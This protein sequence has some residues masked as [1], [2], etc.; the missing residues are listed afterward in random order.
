MST[1]GAAGGGEAASGERAVRQLAAG[2]FFGTSKVSRAAGA[3]RLTES[4]YSVGTVLPRHTHELG[5]LVLV[6]SGRYEETFTRRETFER[7]PM[8]LLYLPSNLPHEERHLEAGRRFMVELPSPF[9]VRMA[10]LGLDLTR[11]HDLTGTSAVAVAR[12]LYREFSSPD[13]ILPFATEALALQLFVRIRREQSPGESRVPHFVRQA[14]E[15]LRAKF[16]ENLSVAALAR[17]VGV[18]PIHLTKAFRR[19]TGHSITEDVRAHRLDFACRE[20]LRGNRTLFDIAI[21]AGY[22][23]HSHFCREFRRHTGMTPGNFRRLALRRTGP[24]PRPA[25]DV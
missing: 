25:G 22:Y 20:M 14:Q 10:E 9:V 11:L 1:A 16:A 7:R 15:I 24:P 3:F 19:W 4:A 13:A 12:Q 17:E 6:L 21:A 8:S 23:D 18:S 5:L 2:R